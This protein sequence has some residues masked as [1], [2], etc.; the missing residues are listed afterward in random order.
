MQAR[1]LFNVALL[2][3]G[4]VL[5]GIGGDSRAQAGPR[6]VVYVVEIEGMIDLGLAPYL[7]RVLRQAEQEGARAVVLHINTFGGRVDAAVKIRDSLLAAKVPTI[8]FIDRRAISAGALISL[9]AQRI[10]MAGGGTIG[11]ATPVQVGGPGG[12][13]QPTDEKTVS[14]VRKEFKST[15]EE[16]GRPPL[17]AEAMV[18]TDVAIPELVEK[19]KLLTLST[20]EALKH[21]VADFRADTLEQ[22]LEQ[23]GLAGAEVRQTSPNWAENVVR[24][25]TQPLLSSLLVT[26]A[27]LGII[28]ELRTPGF[29]IPGLLG[30][31]S[32][33]LVL[34]GH[35]LAQLA[36]M[37][38]M[39]LAALGIALI[40]LE[41]FVIPG[42]GVAGVLGILAL[43]AGLVMTMSGAGSTWA[44][45]I[46]LAS[47]LVFSLL[48]AIALSLV[49]LRFMHR[50][51]G[52][53]RLILEDKLAAGAGYASPPPED[54]DLLGR[55]GRAWSVLRP[56]GIAEIDGERHDVVSNGELIEAGEPIEVIRVDGNRIVVRRMNNLYTTTRKTP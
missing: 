11:A 28:I 52:A 51:P 29:G 17:L 44:F 20:S 7:D 19:G 49:L 16:R 48:V 21:K 15:A 55:T 9:A 26:V 39:L 18:D 12:G 31:G 24:L 47:R 37:E 56:A 6:P 38:E 32:L 27:M 22:V 4:L 30:V 45:L 34:W 36:G 1:L 42:F 50:I 14:Y 33:A 3:L 46:G 8:A 2:L 41:I 25:I 54:H 5:H 35:W 10:A 53:R 40:A 13:T 43:L 23:S